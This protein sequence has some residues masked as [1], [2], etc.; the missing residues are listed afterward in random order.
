MDTQAVRCAVASDV[1]QWL[2]RIRR[3]YTEV[4]GLCLTRAQMQRFWGLES[5][6]CDRLLVELTDGNFLKRTALG[7]YVRISSAH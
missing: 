7:K 5:Q 1:P 6:L 4:P 2:Q 3:E